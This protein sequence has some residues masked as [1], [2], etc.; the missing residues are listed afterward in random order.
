MS[1][2]FSSVC[3]AFDILFSGKSSKDRDSK[4]NKTP[5]LKIKISEAN[6]FH[7]HD[8]PPTT[9]PANM[10]ANPLARP[11]HLTT[12]SDVTNAALRT[13][14]TSQLHDVSKPSSSV[15]S[16]GALVRSSSASALPSH[17]DG[18]LTS[19]GAQA[20]AMTSAST[21]DP[22]DKRTGDSNSATK[23]RSTS[24]SVTSSSSTAI[25]ATKARALSSSAPTPEAV[26]R[27]LK[28]SGSEK[29]RLKT[30]TTQL[31]SSSDAKRSSKGGDMT[32]ST[33]SSSSGAAAKAT[34]R[35][36]KN[37]LDMIVN[38]LAKREQQGDPEVTSEK[39]KF[40]HN[41]DIMKQILMKATDPTQEGAASVVP[42]LSLG[43][44]PKQ[45]P[46][47]A[48]TNKTATPHPTTGSN[49]RTPSPLTTATGAKPLSKFKIPH[50]KSADSSKNH[51]MS[52]AS[53]QSSNKA[54]GQLQQRK[55]FDSLASG[56]ATRTSGDAKRLS[57]V[58]NP[59]PKR[60]PLLA[61]PTSGRPMLN[62]VNRMSNSREQQQHHVTNDKSRKID[63]ISEKLLQ[64]TRH[65]TDPFSAKP[66]ERDSSSSG[67][68]ARPTSAGSGANSGNVD[69]DFVKPQRP[70]P[71]AMR[72]RSASPLLRT[73]SSG[74]S[75]TQDVGGTRMGYT[76]MNRLHSSKSSRASPVDR[77]K[78]PLLGNAPPTTNSQE[79]AV[80][81][82]TPSFY[83]PAQALKQKK[84]TPQPSTITVMA[85]T[86]MTSAP[87]AS[88]V[89]STVAKQSRINEIP[90]DRRVQNAVVTSA[91]T[92]STT[93]AVVIPL[94]KPS[95]SHVTP[96]LNDTPH[97]PL[98]HETPPA[99]PSSGSSACGVACAIPLSSSSSKFTSAPA[100]PAP[101]A[102]VAKQPAAVAR[103][104]NNRSPRSDV[105]SPDGL[106][107]DY[108]H[109]PENSDANALKP[110]AIPLERSD[111]DVI[112]LG[113]DVTASSATP[114]NSAS[115]SASGVTNSC[116]DLTQ[117]AP[118]SRLLL[119]AGARKSSPVPID[120][121]LMNE[122]L[123]AAQS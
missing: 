70:M 45:K 84:S 46:N 86:L 1:Y 111:D 73:A 44:I 60:P 62:A 77:P 100:S 72:Q 24:S 110:K 14:S 8:R 95:P 29:Q 85:S 87:T 121:S 13:K 54:D 30:S 122:A 76:N 69:S 99:S 47:A 93:P 101:V 71:S 10:A 106:V 28:V 108:P 7:N 15:T 56:D 38:K 80:T 107:I 59:Q 74:Q 104:E 33:S 42:V 112:T 6:S 27:T 118:P 117:E 22:A 96:S 19:G 67:A 91:V 48:T 18:V 51:V 11:H 97:S 12:P 20:N 89:T 39:R 105:S 4:H 55:R 92:T 9:S 52:N 68:A 32:S 35:A 26:E 50:N 114:S 120:D 113:N 43:K 61:T 53:A 23:V 75:P 57:N 82:A 17:S 102:V 5:S 109:S 58:P 81:S 94:E 64:Q 65:F 88:S 79:P 90:L 36:R 40:H 25:D 78:T 3:L 21:H 41:N 116:S 16:T 83:N 63:D 115:S 123:G 98:R 34:P 37:S 31:T 2:L 66:A 119:D 49:K 103:K